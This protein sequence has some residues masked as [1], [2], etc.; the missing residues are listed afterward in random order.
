M[1]RDDKPIPLRPE[2]QP[3]RTPS[4]V[5]MVIFL[6]SWAVMFSALFF[7]FAGYRL[8]APTWPPPELP[9]LPLGF[10]SFNTLVIAASSVALHR[11]TQFLKHGQADK[12]GRWL[13]ASTIAAAL[14]F[15]MQSWMWTDLWSSGFTLRSGQYAGYFYLLTVF[16]GLHVLVGLGLLAWLI[17]QAKTSATPRRA[18]RV[19]LAS[20]FWHFVGVVW[21]VTYLLLFVV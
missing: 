8:R 7:V 19:T 2:V 9:R 14:F 12:F 21:V 16:H 4:Y 10:A 20:M 17:P 5:G 15:A 13:W 6:G 3:E 18:L 1:G 11:A